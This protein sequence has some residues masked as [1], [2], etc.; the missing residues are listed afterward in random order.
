MCIISFY[1]TTNLPGDTGKME[2]VLSTDPYYAS[3]L[4][5]SATTK[6]R[7]ERTINEN[8][9]STFHAPLD[10]LDCDT[11]LFRPSDPGHI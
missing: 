5:Q 10:I 4:R 1:Y 7:E 8:G 6:G 3:C 9:L 2:M 11:P